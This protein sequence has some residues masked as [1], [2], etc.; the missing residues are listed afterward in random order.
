MNEYEELRKYIFKY[1][2]EPLTEE[3]V[4]TWHKIIYESK[5]M[6]RKSINDSDKIKF[7]KETIDRVL[8]EHK[9]LVFI[10]RCSICNILARTPFSIRCR[11]GHKKDEGVWVDPL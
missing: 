6:K 10:N 9:D 2:G 3:E 5:K 7:Y 8:R 11:N 1:Y 4:K